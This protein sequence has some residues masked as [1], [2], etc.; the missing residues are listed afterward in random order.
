MSSILR[1]GIGQ[2]VSQSIIP[3]A[4][5]Q[6]MDGVIDGYDSDGEVDEP[7]ASVEHGVGKGGERCAKQGA[8]KHG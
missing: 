7:S 4:E 2:P 3:L 8:A 5:W 6:W 1:E